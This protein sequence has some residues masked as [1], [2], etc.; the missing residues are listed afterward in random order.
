MAPNQLPRNSGLADLL[1]VQFGCA[2]RA[3]LRDRGFSDPAISR[4][5]QRGIAEAILPGVLRFTF[6]PR[7]WE[8]KPM[9]VYLWAGPESWISG[10]TAATIHKLGDFRFHPIEVGTTRH[11]SKRNGIRVHRLQE[12][13]SCDRCR[14][15]SMAVTTAARTIVDCAGYLSARRSEIMLDKAVRDKKTTYEAVNWRMED[16]CHQGRPG[17]HRL[18][19]VLRDRGNGL[20]IPESELESLFVAL[21]RSAGLPQPVRQFRV[22]NSDTFL[23][24]LDFVY[25]DGKINIEVD[26]RKHHVL[27]PDFERDRTRDNE[28]NLMGWI[29]LRFTWRDVLFRPNEVA[30]KIR[31]ALGVRPLF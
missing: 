7:S 9:A 5:V 14:I 13:P 31:H 15:G 19:P 10:L 6:V 25:A 8:Q 1:A 4:F 27:R 12:M 18:R 30:D 29:V 16:L 11:L 23:G 22:G 17:C 28:L 20:A 21:I 2:S 3:Q 24:R 26:G